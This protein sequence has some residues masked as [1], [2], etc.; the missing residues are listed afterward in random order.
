MAD[1]KVE[2]LVPVSGGKDSQV[3]LKMAVTL[4]GAPRV[5]GL[6][7]D[8]GF[9]HP[10]TYQHV[11]KLSHLYGDVRID[12][13]SAGNVLDVCDRFS[14]FPGGKSRHC[15]DYLK[16]RP[17]RRYLKA[18]GLEQQSGFEVWYGMRTGESN[19]RATRYEDKIGNDLHAPHEV[20]PS[21][22]PKYLAKMGIM[23]RLPILEW[24]SSEVLEFIEGEENP[25]Y[26]EGFDRVGC[27]PCLAGGDKWKEKAFKHDAFGR[28]QYFAV[29]LLS[30]KIGKSVWT[31]KSGKERNESGCMVCAI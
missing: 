7:C 31:S 18:L 25:L 29:Q 10:L 19:E 16:I 27:F 20:M 24:S 11:D 9:E 8:T 23:F 4:F 5:R 2:V 22:Y 12:R 15:T 6:F 14:R 3:C 30:T 13:I 21:K 17:T 28:Q 26:A 1:P